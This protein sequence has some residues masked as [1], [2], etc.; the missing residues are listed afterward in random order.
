MSLRMYGLL[1]IPSCTI[2]PKIPSC[3]ARPLFSS[4]PRLESFSS[5]EN[6][7]QPKSIAPFL[8]SPTNS[9]SP[10]M[11]F[12]T[13]SS[14]KP[15]KKK[16]CTRPKGGTAESAASPVGMSANLSPSMSML[17]GRRMPEAVTT[18]PSTA[19]MHTRPCLISTSRRRSKRSWSAFSKIPRG[20]QKPR[21]GCA[22]T[23]VSKAFRA[24]EV[25]AAFGATKAAAEPR[26]RARTA[27][28]N[29]VERYV[30]FQK[31]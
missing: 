22:P 27:A 2:R 24:L 6:E 18:W 31:I 21:G 12:I 9:A 29:I 25:W 14:R 7:S 23:S 5:S 15:A 4:M 3:A 30:T 1:L 26:Q 20:S 10:V 28:R 13:A 8:K 16:I 19:S 17:P 11:S